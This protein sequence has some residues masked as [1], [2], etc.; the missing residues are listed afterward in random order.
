MT[1]CKK[2]HME[3]IFCICE[4]VK[5]QLPYQNALNLLNNDDGKRFDAVK[6]MVSKMSYR[7]VKL[8][9]DFCLVIERENAANKAT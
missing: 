9:T 7:D 1:R 6:C 8:I 5:T 3:F 2:C 4:E